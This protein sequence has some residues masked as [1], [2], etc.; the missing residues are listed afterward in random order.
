VR[1]KTFDI[2][3]PEDC[4][5][6]DRLEAIHGESKFAVPM[7]MLGESIL[8]GEET[9]IKNLEKTVQRLSCAGGASLP[10]LGPSRA[11]GRD[12]QEDPSHCPECRRRPTS[13]GEEWNKIKNFLGGRL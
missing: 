6:F 3:R 9:I 10:Y 5:L 11:E 2:D 4:R 12:A 8:I 13:L 1:V 7:V